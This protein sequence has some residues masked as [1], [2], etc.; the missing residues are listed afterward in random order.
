MRSAWLHRA[1]L[2]P[3]LG[4]NCC[5]LIFVYYYVDRIRR[6][7]QIVSVFHT[8]GLAGGR[9]WKKLRK[10][11]R[12]TLRNRSMHAG[13]GKRSLS[14]GSIRN[15]RRPLLFRKTCS[16]H[17]GVCFC[18]VGDLY[19]VRRRPG[20]GNPIPTRKLNVRRVRKG[21]GCSG[22]GRGNGRKA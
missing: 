1:V 4:L 14:A 16:L 3:G 17:W 15:L 20:K 5:L 7:S 18:P 8:H 10:N 19:E 6:R 13:N 22:K 9:V 11:S 12:R 21:N 2:P